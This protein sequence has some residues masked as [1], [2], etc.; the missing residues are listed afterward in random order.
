MCI[1][2]LIHTIICNYM[3]TL[4]YRCGIPE[5]QF[6][7]IMWEVGGLFN[8]WVKSNGLERKTLTTQLHP[9]GV[10]CPLSGPYWWSQHPVP[11]KPP[12]SVPAKG[13]N[14]CVLAKQ[15][16]ISKSSKS[17]FRTWPHTKQSVST[18]FR[19]KWSRFSLLRTCRI[20]S[21]FQPRLVMS[22]LRPGKV[23]QLGLSK[24]PNRSDVAHPPVTVWRRCLWP[25]KRRRDRRCFFHLPWWWMFGGK[26]LKGDL[27]ARHAKKFMILQW[28]RCSK[29][30][31]I[32][33]DMG[34][35][36]TSP[37]RARTR[38]YDKLDCKTT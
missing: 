32:I 4:T 36:P 29:E 9:G 5:S 22:C 17:H 30:S 2:L 20:L 34:W 15:Q 13:D 16:R 3:H 23:W 25:G 37:R 14:E 33:K 7:R 11:N 8:P 27:F 35:R 24:D 19:Y 31:L 38:T 26:L 1:F 21:P 12:A 28:K 18:H 6:W 10:T